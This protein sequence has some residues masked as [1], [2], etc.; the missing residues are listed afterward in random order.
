VGSGNSYTVTQVATLLAEAMGKPEIKPDIMNKARSGD[1]RNCFSD[2]GKARELLG[3]EPRFRLE[4]TLGELAEWVAQAQAVD[5]SAEM[6]KQ[7][8]ARGLVS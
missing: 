7:L 3:F 1:I 2:I 8:E 4:D 6:K 5:R